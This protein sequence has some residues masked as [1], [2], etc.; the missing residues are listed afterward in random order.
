[1]TREDIIRMAREAELNAHG[2]VID[3]LERFAALVAEQE[4]EECA[5]TV[6]KL[7]NETINC[8]ATESAAHKL[9]K[10]ITF[11]FK[12]GVTSAIRARGGKMSEMDYTVTL[13]AKDLE[14]RERARAAGIPSMVVSMYAGALQRLVEDERGRLLS[15]AERCRMC[16]HREVQNAQT[17]SDE[18]S[19]R[20]VLGKSKQ[21]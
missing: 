1:M 12:E 14:F 21:A 20:T 4:R 19:R 7:L 15:A 16:E 18:A 2:L 17:A 13:T 11:Q 9:V 10:A 8:L 6:E 5:E 3:R